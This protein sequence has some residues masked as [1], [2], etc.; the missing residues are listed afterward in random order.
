[1]IVRLHWMLGQRI[2]VLC[3]LLLWPLLLV[4]RP[5][6]ISDSASYFKGGKAAVEFVTAK[7]TP[8]LPANSPQVRPQG[9]GPAGE[10]GADGFKKAPKGV[11]SVTYSVAAYLL[12]WPGIAMTALALVQIVC[13]AFI[14]TVA[15]MAL[16]V[17]RWRPFLTMGAI[18]AFGT[19]LAPL[20]ANVVPDVF[21]GFVIA[22]VTLLAMLLDRMSM[23]VRVIIASITVFAVTAHPS[24]P[25]L[26]LGL[27]LLGAVVLLARERLGLFRVRWA[28]PWLVLPPLLGFFANIAIGYAAF[29]EV[30][31]SAKRFPTALTRSVVDGPARWY[32]ERHCATEHYAVCEVFGTEIP[33][34]INDFL[35]YEGGLNG[36]ATPEQM[37]R[38]RSE[39]A[40]IVMRAALA[41]PAHEAYN[42][43]RNVIRQLFRFDL[44]QSR[45]KERLALDSVGTP[46]LVPSGLNVQP[47][48]TI[49]GLLTKFVLVICLAWTI[50]SFK[51]LDNRARISVFLVIAGLVGN[52]TIVIAFSSLAS[53][54]QARVIWVLPLFIL[55]IAIARFDGF[56]RKTAPA[57]NE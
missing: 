23:G 30:S 52:A 54:Y 20:C 2:L 56:G 17:Q 46:Q 39:E 14:C 45:F 25:P 42:L 44:G 22:T 7:L 6:Y 49:V 38:I 37:D 41:Y 34:T 26:A 29:G 40:E 15:A 11:R 31:V 27:V 51:R 43:S 55:S 48:M 3:L 28:W 32:L 57:L 47:V 53:R 33:S 24:I 12:R 1:M 4:G 18:V 16:G 36:R 21:S 35:F 10:T 13:A 8:H 5:A 19:P 50:W 9:R